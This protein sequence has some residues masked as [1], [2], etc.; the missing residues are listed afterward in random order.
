MKNILALLFV[1]I[2]FNAKNQT[3]NYLVV[4]SGGGGFFGGNSYW[5]YG[6]YKEFCDIEV[7]NLRETKNLIFE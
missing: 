1:L 3:V 7:L 2:L 5:R 6:L 4:A